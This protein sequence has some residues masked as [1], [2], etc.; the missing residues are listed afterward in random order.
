MLRQTLPHAHANLYVNSLLTS[1]LI[2]ALHNIGHAHLAAREQHQRRSTRRSLVC[3]LPTNRR[4]WRRSRK[5]ADIKNVTICLERVYCILLNRCQKT[6]SDD[7]TTS[8]L[9]V[10]LL[11]K[12]ASKLATPLT[13]DLMQT[14]HSIR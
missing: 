4:R 9:L 8:L 2:S 12:R 7:T 14:N 6:I 13:N 5:M 3:H 10:M 1:K 11:Y